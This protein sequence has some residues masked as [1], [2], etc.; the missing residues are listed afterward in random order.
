M[1]YL[2]VNK[3]GFYFFFK[4]QSNEKYLSVGMALVIVISQMKTT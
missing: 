4:N 3:G 1:S 2:R